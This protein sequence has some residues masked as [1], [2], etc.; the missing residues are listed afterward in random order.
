MEI[1]RDLIKAGVGRVMACEPN[2]HGSFAEFPLYGLGEILQEA[3]ILVLLVDHE[4]FQGIDR[5]LLKEKVLIDY[6][7]IWR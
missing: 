4:E 6:R 5:E 1:T 7:G 2:M 3:D